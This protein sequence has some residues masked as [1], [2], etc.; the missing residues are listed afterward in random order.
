MHVYMC[1]CAVCGWSGISNTASK[2]GYLQLLLL[3]CNYY[4]MQTV[5]WY[6]STAIASIRHI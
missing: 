1:K 4:N 2:T 5:Y 6:I 3:M